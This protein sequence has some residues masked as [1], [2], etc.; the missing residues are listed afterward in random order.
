VLPSVAGLMEQVSVHNVS[1]LKVTG[2]ALPY[3][4]PLQHN[5]TIPGTFYL[6]IVYLSRMHAILT[7]WGS[8]INFYCN[9]CCVWMG[10]LTHG[11]SVN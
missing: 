1:T 3:V 7:R 5:T 10:I 2:Q 4:L 6:P 9:W 11:K 8:F